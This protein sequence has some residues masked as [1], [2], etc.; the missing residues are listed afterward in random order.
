MD[1]FRNSKGQFAE[2]HGITEEADLVLLIASCVPMVSKKEASYS[3]PPS[4]CLSSAT[5]NEVNIWTRP[6]HLYFLSKTFIFDH[7]LKN[8]FSFAN[9]CYSSYSLATTCN[10]DKKPHSVHP[11]MRSRHYHQCLHHF[12]LFSVQGH[13]KISLRL[14]KNVYQSGT[15]W[16]WLLYCMTIQRHLLKQILRYIYIVF[17]VYL[18]FFIWTHTLI[19]LLLSRIAF[20]VHSHCYMTRVLTAWK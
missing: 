14:V 9:K 16:S 15:S 10:V 20:V 19:M 2:F 6:C 17:K 18:Y 1:D 13:V 12:Y 5:Q 3:Y 11:L 4:S 8:F 7:E